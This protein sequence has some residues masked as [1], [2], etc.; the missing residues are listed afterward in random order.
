MNYNKK[1]CKKQGRIEENSLATDY[2]IDG[3]A[4]DYDENS[5]QQDLRAAIDTMG[6]MTPILS[7]QQDPLKQ[8]KHITAKVLNYDA[9]PEQEVQNA[10]V[11]YEKEKFKS[12][13]SE[14]DSLEISN[15]YAS[16]ENIVDFLPSTVA[17]ANKH[18]YPEIK[19]KICNCR[20]YQNY[21]FQ[22]SK[23]K[24]IS[25][26]EKYNLSNNIRSWLKINKKKKST[27]NINTDY[28]KM[29]VYQP[30]D[31][32]SPPRKLIFNLVDELPK[33]KAQNI[34]TNTRNIIN[35]ELTNK[36]EKKQRKSLNY[37]EESIGDLETMKKRNEF[38]H[39]KVKDCHCGLPTRVDVYY[40]DHGNA[41]YLR[42]TDNPPLIKSEI[43]ADKT[44][45]CNTKFWAEIFGTC[46][47]GVSFVTSFLLQLL[48]FTL[49]SIIRPLTI[50]FIQ[51]SSDYFFKPFLATLFNAVIQ[52]PLI[53]IYNI[54][55]SLRDICDPLAE[56]MGYFIK[57]V[58]TLFKACRLVDYKSGKTCGFSCKCQQKK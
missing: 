6:P 46:H 12:S 28:Y 49:Y 11:V 45:E 21:D 26:V 38:L 53:F 37:N 56:G 52:P 1:Q 39:Q 8:K 18:C 19:P 20:H 9:I 57:E 34:G 23:L 17:N 5:L 51:L 54:C 27:Y 10:D 22:G 40:F 36:A 30:K 2:G 3:L 15:S 4:T 47:I 14:L 42:T 50:G 32:N 35:N 33:P 13:V 25:R 24:H 31:D 41:S 44:E 43:I 48:R 58:A 16:K 7:D 55:T 29:D